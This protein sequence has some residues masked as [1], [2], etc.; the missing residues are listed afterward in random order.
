MPKY[1]IRTRF[2]HSTPAPQVWNVFR[3]EYDSIDEALWHFCAKSQSIYDIDWDDDP[4]EGSVLSGHI[5][6]CSTN[7]LHVWRSA[8]QIQIKEI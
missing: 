3:G 1:K 7:G 2:L 5:R 8:T 6:Y 4:R